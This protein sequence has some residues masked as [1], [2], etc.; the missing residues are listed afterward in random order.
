MTDAEKVA[1]TLTLDLCNNL[2]VSSQTGID[3]KPEEREGRGEE[4]GR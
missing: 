1:R 2:R 4:G 3:D